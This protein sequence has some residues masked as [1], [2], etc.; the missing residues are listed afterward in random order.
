[1]RGQ[2]EAYVHAYYPG[3]LLDIEFELILFIRTN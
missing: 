1:M 3:Q 2:N